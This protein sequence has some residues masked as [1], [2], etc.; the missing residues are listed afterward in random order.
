MRTAVLLIAV[1]IAACTTAGCNEP[2]TDVQLTG[3]LIYG[4]CGEVLPWE[5]AFASWVELE[6]TDAVMRFQS[7]SNNI[8]AENDTLLF[9]IDDARALFDDLS[10]PIAVGDREYDGAGASANFTLPKKCPN[11]LYLSVYLHGTLTFE[12]LSPKRHGPIRGTFV[13]EARDQRNDEIVGSALQLHFDFE[14]SSR[15]PWQVFSN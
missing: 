15:T 14:R 9:V 13:G 7:G 8:T 4:E 12:A 6:A 10:T 3:S 2:H 11:E 5:P 1:L